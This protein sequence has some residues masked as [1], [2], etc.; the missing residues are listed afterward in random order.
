M[1]LERFPLLEDKDLAVRWDA[2][3]PSG[4]GTKYQRHVLLKSSKQLFELMYG[5]SNVA[6]KLYGETTKL[7]K[8]SKLRVLVRWMVSRSIWKFSN[9]RQ[10]DI[11][12]FI[13][14]RRPR[15]KLISEKTIKSWLSMFEKMW[16]LRGRYDY[17]IR[18]DARAI[19]DEIYS[20]IRACANR[21][22]KSLDEDIAIGL[23]KDALQWIQDFGP[24]IER[25]AEMSWFRSRKTIGWSRKRRRIESK[26]F[27]KNMAEDLA[28]Q[29]LAESINFNGPIYKT[30]SVA[31]SI[32]EGACAFL[33]LV[34]VGFRASE[35]L[36]LNKDCLVVEA[37]E[38]R[39]GLGYIK[40]VAAKKQGRPRRWVAGIPVQ[41]V[42]HVLL[43]LTKDVRLPRNNSK[44]LFLTRSTGSPL[45]WVGSRPARWS[46]T[47]LVKRLNAFACS[48]LRRGGVQVKHLHPHMLRK[49][50]ARLAVLRDKSRLEAVAAQLG[51]MYQSFTDNRYI[52]VDHDL[53][54]LLAEEDRKELAAGLEQ[55]LTCESIGGKGANALSTV[56]ARAA[57]FRGKKT[58]RAF[59][60]KLIDEGVLLGPCHWGFRVYSRSHSAC[61]GNDAGPNAINRAPDVC[62]VC[63]NLV[64]TE[65]H[66][67][68]WNKRA[69]D[70]E[71]F[72]K[73]PNLPEQ[74]RAVVEEK[75]RKSR[76]V[77]ANIVWAKAGVMSGKAE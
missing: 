39:G 33:L 76:G 69:R 63:F 54:T 70:Q 26:T 48:G 62:A 50:F 61:D 4:E 20:Q 30:L 57:K 24:F 41:D 42:I 47:T 53:V 22:W 28:Y 6:G 77:L 8:F 14:G 32:T 17:S 25:V 31:L 1:H 67:F 65:K 37:V 3:I 59:I 55:L 45:F 74:T 12:D 49:T 7:G 36:S 18:V 44:A 10:K 52:G 68:W 51:H 64:V 27:Y 60:E 34:L 56:R 75:F 21:P 72:L 19:E 11:I 16:D 58:L 66:I 43:R 5:P 35:L 40:G 9:I 2:L 38:G 13:G 73:R 23:I 15:S 46:A 71:M 29:R